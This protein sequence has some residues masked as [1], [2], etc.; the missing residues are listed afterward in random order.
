MYFN[1]RF[2]FP[3]RPNRRPVA[4]TIGRFMPSCGI[5]ARFRFL[6]SS[7]MNGSCCTLAR[8]I[9]APASG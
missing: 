2:K 4:C 6:A 9:I 1:E 7:H 3:F 8:W 5:A